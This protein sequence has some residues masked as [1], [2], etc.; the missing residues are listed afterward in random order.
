MTPQEILNSLEV[1]SNT[2]GQAT[3]VLLLPSGPAQPGKL[4]SEVTCQDLQE[5]VRAVK[6]LQKPGMF[7][8][9]WQP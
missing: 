7:L 6:Q 8:E 3:A 4:A 1:L 9:V 5:F 2:K